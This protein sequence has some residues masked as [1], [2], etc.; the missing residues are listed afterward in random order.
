M[1][2]FAMNYQNDAGFASDLKLLFIVMQLM[3]FLGAPSFIVYLS[4]Y[5]RT[6]TV[7]LGLCH[8]RCCL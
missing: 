6:V 4:K 8:N 5:L 1:N 2:L 3:T 7:Q